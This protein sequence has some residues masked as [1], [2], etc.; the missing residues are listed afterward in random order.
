MGKKPIDDGNS[1]SIYEGW[2]LSQAEAERIRE[3]AEK[4][5]M[6]KELAR[7]FFDE[8]GLASFS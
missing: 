5:R 3:T 2:G 4:K 6:E 8:S 7:G 1:M